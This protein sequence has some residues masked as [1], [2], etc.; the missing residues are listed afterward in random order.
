MRQRR[1]WILTACKGSRLVAYAVFDRQDNIA[2]GLKRVRFVD[3][4]GP[5]GPRKKHCGPPF[6]GCCTGAGNKASTS[7]RM[8]AAGWAAGITVN[9]CSEPSYFELLAVLLQSK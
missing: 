7:W 5:E 3:F 4:S 1:V 2:S 8:S 6:P 9:A